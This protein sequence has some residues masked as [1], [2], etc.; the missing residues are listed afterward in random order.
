MD[1]LKYK[2]LD[3]I[4]IQGNS[5]KIPIIGSNSNDEYM[6]QNNPDR[7]ESI[8]D[9]VST[10]KKDEEEKEINSESDMDILENIKPVY[11]KGEGF[12]PCDYELMKLPQI[13][14]EKTLEEDIQQ[15]KKQHK[16]V[17]N[18]VLQLIIEKQANCQE[19]FDKI[20]DVQK[21]LVE[22]LETV[23]QGRLHL[24]TAKTNFT[25][26]SLGILA[27]Y[28]KRIVMK[29][30]L[31]SLN[32]IKTLH[33][34]EA[35]LQEL[36]NSGDF[37]GSISL[38]LECQSAATTFRHFTCVA[39]LSGKLQDTLVMAEE[40]LDVTLS[41]LCYGFD[42][43]IYSKLQS[44][45]ALLGK[46][47]IAIDQLHMHFTSAVHNS[48]FN[49]VHEYAE[50]DANKKQYSQLCKCVKETDMIKC[51]IALCK[52]LWKIVLS[53]HHVV[54]W[55]S[56]QS[57]EHPASDVA[58]FES[59]MH[60]QY[61][62]Q[63][64]ESG[65]NRLWHDVQTRVSS[66]VLAAQLTNFKF[67]EF[68]QVLGVIH[69]LEQVGEEFCDSQSEELQNSI[70][71][72]SA[73]YFRRYHASRL[74]ELKLFL[75]NEVWAMCPVR[76][77]FNLLHLQE[78]KG[79]RNSLQ[80]CADALATPTKSSSGSQDGSSLNQFFLKYTT[81]NS[82]FDSSLDM[83][84]PQDEDIMIDVTEES[85][86][87][88]DESDDEDGDLQ[89]SGNDANRRFKS[90]PDCTCPLLTNTTLTVLRHC[91]KYLQM[92]R[93]LRSNATDV[94][95]CLSQLFEYYLYSIYTFFASDLPPASPL[96]VASI[97]LLSVLKRIREN[98]ILNPTEE[99]NSGHK[100]LEPNI[101]P[102]VELTNVENLHGLAERIVAVESLAFLAEQF[103]F[104]KP[105]LEQLQP[106][107]HCLHQL[108]N[109]T[110]CV[111]TEVRKPVYACVA[112]R[113]VDV[114]QAIS[115]M[116][117]V[118][119]EVQDVRSE[120]S[121]YVDI[122]LREL[123]IFSMRLEEVGKNITITQ[124]VLDSLWENIAHILADIFVE[125][126]S[127]AKKCSNGGRGLMQLDFTQLVSQLERMCLLKPIPHREY[128]EAYVK[129]YY[130][131]EHALEDFIKEHNE[132]STKQL[133]AL[134]SCACQ[135]NKKM[136]QKLSAVI[137][138]QDKNRVR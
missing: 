68:L 87:Y 19:E 37:S 135:S 27:N 59:S 74:D 90:K 62:K 83:I 116:S 67:D 136:K 16:V 23:R 112:W 42:E 98:L 95:L 47:Q 101:S 36:L 138:E 49:V 104:L 17:S 102:V 41:K 20:I 107:S 15:L 92:S 133:L 131:M 9:S 31:R 130:L 94:I 115:L 121:Q 128:V 14:D 26:A 72:Q 73:N 134:V 64:L 6:E 70:K 110:V 35:K 85:K 91:G 113:S 79:L 119:W 66:L 124:F 114:K 50:N 69:R 10:N 100:V 46:T 39:A 103:I 22:T 21:Q 25:T 60:E 45:Y 82:P 18:K 106:Q 3:L 38:L 99:E 24:N 13:L 5:V 75:E 126:F 57:A 53:Y 11:F 1:D 12:D 30:L 127:S 81:E 105:Y 108:Y 33:C 32:T 137:E 88:S 43:V 63:K 117:R 2:L 93:L 123:Q 86:F 52:A 132:Y 58:D 96:N 78:F 111:A 97:K 29:D 61:V 80:R 54:K 71:T 89:S 122:L 48:A 129:A 76:P 4:N 51:L 65:L 118:N 120:H 7:S 125:G 56:K 109:Q 55:H 77:D 34:T 28:K 84:M 40:Q 8:A 44:A